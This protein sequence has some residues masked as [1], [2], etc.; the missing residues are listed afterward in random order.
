MSKECREFMHSRSLIGQKKK[1]VVRITRNEV[2]TAVDDYLKKGG[3]IKRIKPIPDY[4]K[5][6]EYK[7]D[8]SSKY[9]ADCFLM[10]V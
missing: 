1:R 10:G 9:N 6:M 2:K 7:P 5:F 3:R 8:P 4:D